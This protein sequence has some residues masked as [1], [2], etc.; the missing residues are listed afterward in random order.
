MSKPKPGQRRKPTNA[1]K[2]KGKVMTFQIPRG[3]L[4]PNSNP[5]WV[6]KHP[7]AT[8]EFL[9]L[10]PD[11]IRESD[12]RSAKEQISERYIG[13]WRKAIPGFKMLPNGNMDY[14]GDPELPIYFETILHK[15]KANQETLRLYESAFLAIIQTDDAYEIC[16]ID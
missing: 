2:K 6:A 13:G 16:F 4:G 3:L 8:R 10:I 11:I 9:G 1:Q 5:T 14:P 12:P 7:Y 15:G